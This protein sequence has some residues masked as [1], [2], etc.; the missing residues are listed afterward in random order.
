MTR[1]PV[2][3]VLTVAALLATGVAQAD[4]LA[5]VDIET[6][7]RV[8]AEL[9]GQTHV[10]TY[11]APCRGDT[12]KVQPLTEV[13]LVRV[14]PDSELDTLWGVE[15]NFDTS[16]DLAYIYVWK[17]GHWTNLGILVGQSPNDVPWRLRDV[18]AP[19][20]ALPEF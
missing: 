17:H 1:M 16:F 14:N 2:S 9:S 11:C 18:P 20:G 3:R 12:P 7:Q 15:S 13:K 4:Q 5:F 8:V 6:A 10:V 19:E